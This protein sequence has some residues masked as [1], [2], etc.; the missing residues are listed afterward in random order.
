MRSAFI[1]LAAIG[2]AV[3][4]LVATCP[5]TSWADTLDC[6][7]ASGSCSGG[8]MV[9]SNGVNYW[10]FAGA[11]WTTTD[12]H[13]TSGVIDSFVRIHSNTD[14]EDGM[15]TSA[16]PLKNDENDSKQFTTDLS[17]TSVP[18]VTLP[19]LNGVGT[20]SYYEFLLDINQ[21]G[22]DPVLSLSGLQLCSARN[23]GLDFTDTCAGTGSALRYDLDG[24]LN[25][26]YAISQSTLPTK[27]VLLNAAFNR[28]SGSGDMFVYIPTSLVPTGTTSLDRNSKYLYLWSQFGQPTNVGN[29]NDGYEEWAV[30]ANL[31]SATPFNVSN[32]EPAS[33]LLLGTGLALT[34]KAIRRARKKGQ[35][36]S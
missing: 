30:R 22:S 29:A 6:S 21:Q 32:P 33:L 12:S 1:K 28:G 34:G 20:Q 8:L 36:S 26:P 9:S 10:S 27:N 35:A 15:N 17:R 5:M 23:G 2:A 19:N 4:G 13:A 25:A 16:R 14:V 3:I 18:T 24:N 31:G 7:Q 11:L